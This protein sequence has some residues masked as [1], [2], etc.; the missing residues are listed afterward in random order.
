MLK[1]WEWPGDEAN[2]QSDKVMHAAMCSNTA[3]VYTRSNNSSPSLVA[4]S[5]AA[6][7]KAKDWL[8]SVN[9]VNVRFLSHGEVVS[10]IKECKEEVTF[11]LTTPERFETP[12]P[13]ETPQ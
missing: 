10:M 5:Q 8:L 7:V 1:S 9:G 2:S 4:H 13:V 6:G 3:I 12:N 11:E